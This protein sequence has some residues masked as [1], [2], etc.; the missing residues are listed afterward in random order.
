M[1]QIQQWSATSLEMT[2]QHILHAQTELE[3]VVETA[4]LAAAA[5]VGFHPDVNRR[6]LG[7]LPPRPV[8]VKVLWSYIFKPILG[9]GKHGCVPHSS[10]VSP[11]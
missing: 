10:F 11:S 8:Q 9:L 7:P 2:R 5:P 6:L 3:K 4:H 1:E